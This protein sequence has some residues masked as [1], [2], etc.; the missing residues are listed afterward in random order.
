MSFIEGCGRDQQVMFPPVL[1][2]YIT[3]DNPVRFID[4][5]AESLSVEELGFERATP[6]D[7]GR[8]GY[9]P[10][11]M[12][13]LYLYGY[14]NG[15]RSSR[16]LERETHRNVELMWLMR[17]LRPDF[18]TIADF[19]RD[20]GEAIRQ[21]CR[22]FSLLC[23][24]MDLFGGEL[25]AIDGSK[26]RAV[27]ART[28][29]F[30]RAELERR[31]QEIDRR[32]E[33]YFRELDEADEQEA[34]ISRPT[35]EELRKKI[36]ELKQ[37]GVKFAELLEE[38]DRTGE[39]QVSLTDPDSRSMRSGPT[40]E[41]CY[42]AQTVVD[43]KHKLIVAN[44][45]TNE[46]VDA[47]QLAPMARQAQEILGGSGFS[48]VADQ[49]YA[50]ANHVREC[51]DH[52]ITPY[53]PKPVTSANGP[54]GL[55]TKDDFRYDG[56]NDCYVCPADQRLTFRFQ[57]HEK[58]RAVRYYETSACGSCSLKPECTRNKR[59]RRISRHA[60]EHVLEA[61][62][63]RMAASPDVMAKRKAIVEH[64]FGTIK[65][66]MGHGFFLT[67]GLRNVKAEFSLSALAYN[68]KRVFKIVGVPR[69]IAALG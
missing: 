6:A 24:Q 34:G 2:D 54:L 67:R 56:E 48:V 60:D 21:V 19:R 52:G 28:R 42:N 35:A 30:N 62:R 18:K 29:N 46:G 65:R 33:D 59:N 14:G 40:T 25:L 5:F 39:R 9:D 57:T 68:M 23:R 32:I 55:F 43:E 63:Q 66:T 16:K 38:L 3:S 1:D 41:V 4:A 27:N 20:N 49:G 13:R 37:K 26:F 15:L 61:M 50:S 12:I 22:A 69:M 51:L 7:T 44:D 53:V 45:V 11:D 64:P 36:E 8:P 10:K 31:T 47:T 17:Q 58:G